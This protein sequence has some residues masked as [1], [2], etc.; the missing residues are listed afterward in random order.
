MPPDFT[1]PK[2]PDHHPLVTVGHL[3]Y[4]TGPEVIEAIQSVLDNHYPN[5]QHIVLDDC[6][7]DNSYN[8]IEEFVATTGANIMLLR[9]EIN[10]GITKSNN[11]ILK[12]AQGKYYLGVSDDILMPGKIK[13]DVTIL[14][15][16]PENCFAVAS[17]GQCFYSDPLSP[18]NSFHGAHRL[19][20]KAQYIQPKEL[21]DSLYERNWICA[22]T[23]M[24]RT[25]HLRQFQ[26]PEDY[27][28]EDY[29]YWIRNS[30]NGHSIYYRP[31]ATILY[32]RSPKSISAQQRNSITSLKIKK[33]V[34]RCKLTIANQTQ[35]HKAIPEIVRDGIP[36]LQHGDPELVE[37]Y[38]GFI[39]SLEL[40]GVIYYFSKFSI[41]R[42]W[43]RLA[44]YLSRHTTRV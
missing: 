23:V 3:C 19:F 40:K 10:Q 18:S 33:D 5:I 20:D 42:Y 15:T 11:T 41:N 44:W 17:V 12:L 4:N 30:I 29:P 28:I 24:S 2:C 8:L 32:R 43:L 13:D 25:A 34:I 37:W 1:P 39:R 22:P 7:E 26:Y 36:L 21:L 6:S 9:N 38:L 14:E 31:E 27:F 16:C 35:R